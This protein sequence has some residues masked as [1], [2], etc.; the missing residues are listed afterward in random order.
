MRS[1]DA[2][3]KTGGMTLSFECFSEMSPRYKHAL[4]MANPMLLFDDALIII[5]H[6]V[7]KSNYAAH[8]APYLTNGKRHSVY[9]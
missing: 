7:C 4:L 1:K 9:Y 2:Q 6:G 5:G 8:D 3:C